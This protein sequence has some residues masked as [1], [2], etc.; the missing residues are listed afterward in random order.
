MTQKI[1][2][3]NTLKGGA[4]LSDNCTVQL[5]PHFNKQP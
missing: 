3:L 1:L 4:Y 5:V 2:L